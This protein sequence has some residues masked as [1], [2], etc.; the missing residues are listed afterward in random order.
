MSDRGPQ[1]P[2]F[3]RS[4][5]RTREICLTLLLGASHLLATPIDA[6]SG[7]ADADSAGGAAWLTLAEGSLDEFD[8]LQVLPRK[9]GAARFILGDARGFARVYERRDK[10][11][12]EIW[13]SE[14]F[15]SA[16]GGVFI[17]DLEGDGVDE[18]ALYTDEG[19]LYFL[20]VAD[21]HTIWSNP[22]DEYEQLT[23]AAIY[24]VDEDDQK[25]LLLCADGRL[26]I[27]DGRDRFEEWHSDQVDLKTTQIIV[28]DVDGDGADEI[29]LNDGY[30]FDARFLDLEWQSAVAFG[31]R[32]ATLDVDN[33]DIPEVIGEFGSASLRIFD[34]DLRRE[35]TAGE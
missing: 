17:A 3:R 5:T 13:V 30:V 14:F 26:V 18:I 25:E 22:P 31:Q 6:E 20:D 9:K 1:C 7:K 11:F 27:Y 23:A 10:G 29:V 15:E 8:A 33:D 4:L 21:Y 19:R 32:I 16:I 2:V 34:I 12:H 24:D 28:A 35:K